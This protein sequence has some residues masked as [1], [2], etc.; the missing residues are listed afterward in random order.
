MLNYGEK[1][2][3]GNWFEE[4]LDVLRESRAT[5]AQAAELATREL[6]F[7]VTEG[8]IKGIEDATG[9]SFTMPKPDPLSTE[10]LIEIHTRMQAAMEAL[11]DA[12]NRTV[13]SNARMDLRL[14]TAFRDIAS[15]KHRLNALVSSLD[16]QGFKVPASIQGDL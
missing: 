1:I 7:Q 9:L 11:T 14:S 12:T 5:R 4:K 8:N 13:E 6:E 15:I 10:M 2:R 16:G 3:L